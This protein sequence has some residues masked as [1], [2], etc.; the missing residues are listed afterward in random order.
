MA[1]FKK[2]QKYSSPYSLAEDP[3]FSAVGR[4]TYNPADT[5]AEARAGKFSKNIQQPVPFSFDGDTIDV[6][7]GVSPATHRR[8]G[9]PSSVSTSKNH[10]GY[11][12]Q[13]K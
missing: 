3:D 7:S 11:K 9:F 1:A 12:D 10:P 6:D 13:P 8:G 2:G 4:D 5:V